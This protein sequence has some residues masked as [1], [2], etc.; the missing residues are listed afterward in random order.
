M[1]GGGRI[2]GGKTIGMGNPTGRVGSVQI[3]PPA[4]WEVVT[5]VDASSSVKVVA[6][7]IWEP[8]QVKVYEVP[9]TVVSWTPHGIPEATFDAV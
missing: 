5:V 6:L 2:G 3:K 8:S 1:I 4:V 7:L 9:E